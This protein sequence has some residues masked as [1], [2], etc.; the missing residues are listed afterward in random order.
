MSSWIS[1]PFLNIEKL[2]LLDWTFTKVP[3]WIGQL[4]SLREL[5]LG[6]K[7]IFQEDV[8][9]IG[10][11]LPLLVHLS[12]RLV[13]GIPAEEKG[14]IIADS[15]GFMALRFFC[16]DSSRMSYLA[17]GAG[18]MPQVRRLL[19]GL[20]PLEW[21]EATPIG[22]ENLTRLV[23]MRVLSFDCIPSCCCRS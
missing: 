10:T 15:M 9:M 1:P 17:F 4:H 22:L 19:L 5:A 2:D 13:P 8:S 12:L 11:G 6:A 23:E 18:A 7:Q 20:D 16:F 14:V 21:D 3:R